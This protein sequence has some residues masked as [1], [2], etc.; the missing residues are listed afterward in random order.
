M[1]LIRRNLRHPLID[2]IE[3]WPNSG[4]LALMEFAP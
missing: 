1:I 4:L 2:L 3:T